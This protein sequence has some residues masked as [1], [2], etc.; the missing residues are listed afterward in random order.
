MRPMSKIN[1]TLLLVSL[2]AQGSIDKM[3][4]AGA[5]ECFEDGAFLRVEDADGRVHW[6]PVSTI[7]RVMVEPVAAVKS[8]A[9]SVQAERK[10]L[11]DAVRCRANSRATGHT[12]IV[13]HNLADDIETGAL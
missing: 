7:L 13:L 10:R 9:P 11:A 1:V 5:T 8:E 4:F 12:S 3:D 2:S 6:F